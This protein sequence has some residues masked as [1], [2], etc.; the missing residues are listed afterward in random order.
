MEPV[1]FC[2]VGVGGHGA[3][4]VKSSL[5]LEQEA[6]GEISAVVIRSPEKHAKEVDFFE[7]RGVKIYKD[8]NEML[9]AEKGRTE[10]VAL[11]TAIHQHKEMTIKALKNG[12]NVIVEKPPAAT[13]QDLDEMLAAERKSGKF[14]AVSFQFLYMKTVSTL[15]EYICDG[16]LGEIKKVLVK[17]KW[18]RQ[19]SYYERTPWA[20]KFIYDGQYV[21]DGTINN[22]LAHYLMNSLYFASMEMGEAAN[23]KLV[24]AELYKGHRIEGEDTSCL[25]AELHSGVQ[26]FFFATLCSQKQSNPSHR[27][28][29]TKGTADWVTE[30]EVFI[31]YNDGRCEVIKDDDPNEMT[32]VFRN[33]ARYLR[34]MDETINCPLRITRPFVLAVN[35]AYESARSIKQIPDKYIARKKEGE[36]ISTIIENID[37]II[38]QSFEKHKLYSDLG[39]K[40]AYKTDFFCLDRYRHF[41]MKL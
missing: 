10:I 9:E 25:Q 28:I 20:G 19:D 5:I 32:N 30:E 35:G 11:P 23:P 17:G 6:L 36:S 8:Y 2:I 7:S 4:H 29:G 26:V 31:K 33:V 34:G 3:R 39:I 21:L 15:K 24:R 18:K 16:K 1:S 22:P 14:C 40:W 37:E 27:I 13:I 41:D 38:D 12:Y